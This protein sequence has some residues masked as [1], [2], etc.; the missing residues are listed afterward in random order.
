MS[1]NKSNLLSRFGTGLAGLLVLLV[2]IGA[3]N[4]I[5][6]NLRLRVDL[7]AERL[8][9]LS[10]G[11]KQ[12]LGKLENDVTLKFY[13]SAS[14]AEMPMGL[15]T[16]AN[17][18]QDLLKEYEL[19]GKGRVA[20]E[21]YD[22]KPDSDSEEWAQRYGIEPQQTNPFGQ[23]VYFGLVAVCG[24]TEAVIPGFNPRTEA[25]L[26]YDITRLITRVAWPEKPVIGVLSSLSVLGAPQ[27]PMMM[28][29]RQQQDQGWTAFRELRKDYT[30]REIQADAEAIDADVKALIVVHPKNLEDKALFAIDQFVLRGGRLIVCVD[31]FNIADFEANQQQQNPMMMQMGGGQAGP[32]TLG[33]LFDAWGVTFDT[34]KI[35]ADLS[36]ATKL[37]SGNGR[38]EDNPAFLSLGT[39]NMA[40]DDLLTAQLSQVMLPFAGALSANT[41]KEITFTPLITTSKD[42][43]CLVDQMNAQF[44][45]SAMRAQLKPDGAQRTLAARLQGTFKTAFP[46]GLSTNGTATAATNAA[47]AHL[48][49]GTST[50]MIFGDA[51]FLNDRFCVQVMN[52]L[53][54]QVAQPIN[55][56]LT[57]FGNTVEQFA[58][59]EELIGVRSR[60][61][62]NRPFVKVDQL[63]VKAMKQWQAEEERLEAALQETQ[64]RLADLQQKK[65]GNERLILSKEQQAELEQFRKT[66]AETR[67]QLKEVRKNLNKDIERLGLSLK[68]VNIALLPLLVIGF[69]LF[70]GLRRRKH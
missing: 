50:V 37:N 42:N 51:D 30:V 22:P 33:K 14:S 60:G 58:G 56:N 27:N 44:G 62:F 16:Y 52:S 5:I 32:S 70:R 59:R 67:K 9:T 17:Q 8:Y 41:P 45:M 61:Q 11:S 65:S 40:K 15:K 10:T 54:G 38:V 53:F 34:A 39:A 68:V 31:P 24:E 26:E 55:D 48:T 29:R 35:V 1:A 64:Q 25:T 49:S 69:G 63:E 23:P 12:V 13:F 3:A 66:Q 21:A 43:A 36:A 6:A 7:T 28:M 18:V 2:I 47:P 57:L 4:L 19:A 20:L 46:D